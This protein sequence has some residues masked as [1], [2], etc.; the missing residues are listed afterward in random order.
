MIDIQ[1]NESFQ[2]ISPEFLH[3]LRTLGLPNHNIRLKVG[4]PIM[5]LRNLN[6]S[7]GLSNGT[8]LVVTKLANH[9]IEAKF[10]STERDGNFVYISRMSLSPSQSPWP[11]KLIRRRFP[12]VISYAMT[13][14]KSQGQSL[15]NV[16][17]YLPKLV[18]SH[19]QLYVAISRVKK[20]KEWHE[21]F[22]YMIM[23]TIH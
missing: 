15:T 6:Q 21:D 12:M 3:C 18:F 23:K 2:E 22:W 8:R 1:D 19:G 16:G 9:V 17:L 7:E 11:F 10:M 20:K 14:N 5:L 13:I 4:T